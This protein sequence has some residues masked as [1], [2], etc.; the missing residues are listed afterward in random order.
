MAQPFPLMQAD[1]LKISHPISENLI[2]DVI[3]NF[4]FD[5]GGVICNLDFKRTEQRFIGLGFQVSD[6]EYAVSGSNI[7]DDLETG[8]ISP[9]EFRDKLRR[10]FLNPVTDVQIDDAWNALLLDIPE[11]RIRLLEKLRKHKRIFLL[12]NSNVIHYQKYLENFRQHYGYPDFD[13]LF[14]KAYFSFRLGCRK[15]SREIFTHVLDHAR[16]NP[17][18]TLFI[19]DTLMHV[20]A[21]QA[22]GIHA[23]HLKID[24]GEQIMDLFLPTR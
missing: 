16:L 8:D 20:K 6:P 24:A 3:E 19:D 10:F 15:P 5:F 7:F 9:Q 11:P 22:A 12:S 18:K 4:I 21:A 13:A 2:P 14:E 17:A 23:H 1:L